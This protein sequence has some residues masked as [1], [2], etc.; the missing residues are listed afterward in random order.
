[1]SFSIGPTCD[2]CSACAQQCP[3]AAIQGEFKE[4]YSIVA[5]LCIDCGV[6]GDICPKE[7]VFDAKGQLALRVP[8][9]QRLR[10]VVDHDLCNGCHLCVDFCPFACLTVTGP[11]YLGLA[12]LAS[13]QRCVSCSD[14][15]RVCIKGAITMQKVDLRT[16]VAG[17]EALRATEDL[18]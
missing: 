17:D 14:C 10:P 2:G 12:Y 11:R 15:E 6:C 3:V 8:R 5:S 16:W 7:A 1:M 9:D 4:M 13:A 18:A